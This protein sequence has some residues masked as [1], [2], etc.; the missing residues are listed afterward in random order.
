MIAPQTTHL[1]KKLIWMITYLYQKLYVYTGIPEKWD[2]AP[3]SSKVKLLSIYAM[4]HDKYV[5]FGLL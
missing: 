3:G 2:A 5:K 1:L 4:T